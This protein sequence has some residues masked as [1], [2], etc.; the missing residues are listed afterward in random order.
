MICEKTSLFLDWG[1][2]VLSCVHTPFA[3]LHQNRDGSFGDKPD[4]GARGSA[5]DRLH[6][7]WCCS[8]GQ[9]VYQSVSPSVRQSAS[10]PVHQS[11]SPSVSQSVERMR[12]YL[13][14]HALTRCPFTTLLFC[15][16]LRDR[17]F[18]V[19]A[20]RDAANEWS[21]HMKLITQGSN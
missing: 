12:V 9:S 18:M 17:N 15:A 8:Q 16:A 5:Y 4:K 21:R 7:A 20:R 14:P 13:N 2:Q 6:P 1:Y 19:D 11:V 3:T 10:Q